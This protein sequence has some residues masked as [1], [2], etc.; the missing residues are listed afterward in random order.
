MV[1]SKLS[2]LCSL[3]AVSLLGAGNAMAQTTYCFPNAVGVPFS[4]GAPTVI[5]DPRWNGAF[6]V[7]QRDDKAEFRALT[8]T[9]AGQTSLVLTW[10]IQGD[11]GGSTPND[12]D[13]ITVEFIDDS[14]NPPTGNLLR[15]Q[16]LVYSPTSAGTVAAGKLGVEVYKYSGTL[17]AAAWQFL[18]SKGIGTDTGTLPPWLLNDALIDL[19]C[20]PDSC[21][22][23]TLTTKIPLSATATP[24][25]PSTGLKLPARF[26]FSY[27]VDLQHEDG[28]GG[29]YV[30]PPYIWNEGVS[31]IDFGGPSFPSPTTLGYH[32]KAGGPAPCATGISLDWSQIS[33]EHGSPAVVGNEIAINMA[34]TFRARPTNGLAV[35]APQGAVEATFRI[36]DWGAVLGASPTWRQVPSCSAVHD[37]GLSTV[38]SGGAFDISC[39]WTLGADDQCHYGRAL[40]PAAT[41]ASVPTADDRNAH[42]CV[43]VE[44]RPTPGA[45]LPPNSY[46]SKQSAYRNMDFIKASKFSRPAKLELPLP[47]VG[48]IP[49]KQLVKARDAYVF[50]ETTGMDVP[51]APV[52][53]RAP[54]LKAPVVPNTNIVV[55]PNPLQIFRDPKLA[56]RLVKLGAE[57][58]KI[59]EDVALVLRE[60]FRLG[61]VTHRE[62]ASILPTYIVHVWHDTGRTTKVNGKIAKVLASAPPFGY[63]VAHDGELAGW[64][65]GITGAGAKKIGPNLYRI[66]VPVKG[67]IKA[68]TWLQ[69]CEDKACTK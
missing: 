32:Q 9:A 1:H 24:D 49:I 27:Q 66:N 56:E 39:S 61:K 44:L 6:A 60:Q 62:I 23:W 59:S 25:D 51:V 58:G 67:G 5:T 40:L 17:T 21:S 19:Q 16:R 15:F 8:F 54:V 43:F 4:T 41:C 37:P 53:L 29:I 33:V 18:L 11:F 35:P 48:S 55:R 46:F 36:A 20:S 2:Y 28:M 22:S 34:N 14:T 52:V 64:K 47:P 26:R 50:I 63:Y 12:V 30:E 65:Y 38:P 68:E 42:Q 45:L 10:N 31:P 57:K 69:A 13:V 7:G 3:I